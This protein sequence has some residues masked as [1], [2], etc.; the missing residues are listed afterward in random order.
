MKNYFF[1]LCINIITQHTRQLKKIDKS[2]SWK[3][4]DYRPWTNRKRQNR[5]FEKTYW[6][7]KQRPRV[8]NKKRKPFP[9]YNLNDTVYVKIN[10]R[11][12]NKEEIVKEDKGRIILTESGKIVHKSYI[13]NSS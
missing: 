7:T 4:R 5:Q 12:G 8:H 3:N 6:Q 9:N 11:L 13:R 10:K 1:D 2:I